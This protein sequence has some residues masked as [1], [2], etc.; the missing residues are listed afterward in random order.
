M[1]QRRKKALCRQL[2]EELDKTIKALDELKTSRQRGKAA[3]IESIIAD[4]EEIKS[5]LPELLG[6][7]PWILDILY[8][9]VRRLLRFLED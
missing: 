2:Q 6:S 4:L 9:P 5:R 3:I 7:R 8:L 1:S